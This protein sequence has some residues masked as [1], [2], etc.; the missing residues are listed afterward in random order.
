MIISKLSPGTLSSPK[1]IR[2]LMQQFRVDE[3]GH[4]A[5]V[6]NADMGYGWLH[7]GIIRAIKPENVLC[8]GSRYGYIPAVMA[9]ACKDNNH[10]HVDFVDAGYDQTDLNHWTGVG[11]WNTNKGKNCFKKHGLDSWITLHVSTTKDFAKNHSTEFQ[12]IY[13]D[14][15]HSFK[16]ISL[17][18]DLFWPKLSSNGFMLFHDISITDHRPEGKYGVY[19]FW[20][21]LKSQGIEFPHP[22]SGLGVIQKNEQ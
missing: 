21:K 3:N 10:G 19:K 18:Y 9:Q 20:R 6:N 14:G 5:N 1:N 8:V 11:Y 17:D 4:Q 15:D 16:G 12:Y 2:R 22:W 7:Y 13:I